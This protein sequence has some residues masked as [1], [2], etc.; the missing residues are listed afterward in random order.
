MPVGKRQILPFFYFQKKVRKNKKSVNVWI[1]HVFIL[2]A[3]N[4][5]I[6]VAS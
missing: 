4:T 6:H 3:K 2:H 5:R 1:L